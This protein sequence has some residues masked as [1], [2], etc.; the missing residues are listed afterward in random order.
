MH[1]SETWPLAQ[2]KQ[3]STGPSL[4]DDYPNLLI[5]CTPVVLVLLQHL[6]AEAALHW[7]LYKYKEKRCTWVQATDTEIVVTIQIEKVKM[8]SFKAVW[9]ASNSYFSSGLHH[10]SVNTTLLT[11]GS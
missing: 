1:S 8:I 3:Y 10:L 5:F 9:A 7:A 11:V 6:W 4:G 2:Q